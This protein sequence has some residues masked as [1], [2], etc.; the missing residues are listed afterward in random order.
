MILSFYGGIEDL[1]GLSTTMGCGCT[2]S[3]RDGIDRNNTT[4]T[5]D[6]HLLCQP[7]PFFMIPPFPIP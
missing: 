3:C 2:C 7:I 1:P 5:C 4:T 6:L